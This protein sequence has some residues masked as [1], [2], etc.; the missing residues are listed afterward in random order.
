LQAQKK[1]GIFQPSQ[2]VLRV[3]D[4]GSSDAVSRSYRKELPLAIPSYI[5]FL[6]TFAVS[7]WTGGR[8]H[9]TFYR[10]GAIEL[11]P[12][13]EPSNAI[14][15]TWLLALEQA[16]I[17]AAE[18][19]EDGIHIEIRLSIDKPCNWERWVTDGKE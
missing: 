16:A 11:G 7:V 14:H 15:K 3:E 19:P 13:E 1:P 17:R 5:R 6:G 8:S 4:T 12:R 2:S 18:F 10:N 9:E